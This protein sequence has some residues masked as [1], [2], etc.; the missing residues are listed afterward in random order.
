MINISI[1]D[2]RRRPQRWAEENHEGKRGEKRSTLAAARRRTR[3]RPRTEPRRR[4]FE[5]RPQTEYRHFID[6]KVHFASLSTTRQRD[7][8]DGRRPHARA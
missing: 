6:N 8:A 4:A 7:A 2:A 5:R 3:L 1:D